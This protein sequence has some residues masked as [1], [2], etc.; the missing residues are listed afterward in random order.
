MVGKP[1][2]RGARRARVET[3]KVPLTTGLPRGRRLGIGQRLGCALRVDGN[4]D[5]LLRAEST[6]VTRRAR[7]RSL[8]PFP[9]DSVQ[10]SASDRSRFRLDRVRSR[11]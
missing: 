7:L 10:E 2:M 11:S 6:L 8:L 9:K 1:S 5:R 4:P 3:A